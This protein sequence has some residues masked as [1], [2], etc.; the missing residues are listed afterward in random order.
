M[1]ETRCPNPQATFRNPHFL[2]GDAQ[3]LPFANQSFDVIT[4]GYGLRNLTSWETGVT[5][6]V[7]VAARPTRLLVLDFGKPENGLWRALYFGYLRLCVPIFGLL[8]CG[9]ASAYAH[10]LESSIA[11]PNGR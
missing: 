6:M 4:V 10:I 11:P 3:R 9:K 1:A 5:E 2:Q 8:F 7:R